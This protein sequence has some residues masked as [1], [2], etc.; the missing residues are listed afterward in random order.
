MSEPSFTPEQA[1]RYARQLSLPNVGPEGQQR[2]LDATV[3]LVGAGGLGSPM[4]LYLAGAGVGRLIVIDGDT[5]D[6]SNLQRQVL[7]QTADVGRPK[8]AVA[9]ERIRALNPDVRVDVHEVRL[10]ASN[11]MDLL[12]PADIV[13]D[14][15]DNFP[16]RYLVNDACVLTGKPNA[17]GSIYRFEGQ[18]SFFDP[19][20]GPCYR[21]LHPDPPP[22]GL[23]PT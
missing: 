13:A 7:F 6:E 14:G 21:C 19:D 18:V 10:D 3:A 12:G 9:A 20:G 4:A 15:S 5:V 1:R 8:A 22:P 16:T 2:L 17:H 23:V 11:A